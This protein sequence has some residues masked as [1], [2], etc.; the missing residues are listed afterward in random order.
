MRM[1]PSKRRDNFGTN[2]LIRGV[3]SPRHDGAPQ[4]RIVVF[5]EWNVLGRTMTR[6]IS[7]GNCQN[8][9]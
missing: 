8:I 3:Q 5:L 6:R 9:Y 4:V 7:D 2:H 1:D